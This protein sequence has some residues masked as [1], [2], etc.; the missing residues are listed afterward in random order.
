MYLYIYKS[1]LET[2]AHRRTPLPFYCCLSTSAQT[3]TTAAA[4]RNFP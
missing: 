4:S 2:L 3:Y 1:K